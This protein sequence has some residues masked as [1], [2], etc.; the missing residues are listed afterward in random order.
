MVNLN[1]IG[2]IHGS[3][4]YASHT[5]QLVKAL[6]D[7]GVEVYLDSPKYP[8][9]ESQVTDAELKTMKREPFVNSN[10]LA[11]V[12][13]HQLPMILSEAHKNLLVY[14]VWEGSNVPNFWIN[15]FND[16]SIMGILCP[17]KHTENAVKTSLKAFSKEVQ[18]E[19]SSKLILCPHGVDH[20]LFK[21]PKIK[22]ENNKFTFLCNKGWVRGMN[23][24]G[25]LQYALKAFN[26]EFSNNEP[27]QLLVKLNTAYI[28][29][30]WD[31]NNE[32]S[33]LNL[34]P[35]GAVISITGENM[36][37]EKLPDFYNMG[38]VLLA[39]NM[40]ESFGLPLAEAMACG[41][42]CITTNY[43]GQTDFVTK[44]NG[45]LVDYKLKEVTWDVMYEGVSWAEPDLTHFKKCMRE[46]YDN[47]E[48]VKKKGEQAAKD[49]QAYDWKKTAKII[50]EKLV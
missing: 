32:L 4:G 21:T 37:F 31:L 7:L 29:Q 33:K 14:C 22:V 43:G 18:A 5:R 20:N 17:S 9:W 45:W 35:E 6:I 27:V 48:L 13:P 8:G 49:I 39:P 28:E 38:D 41:L 12:L 47:L 10:T 2:H 1:V 30:G 24:R 36:P 3:S 23:D 40:S 50:K 15:Y 16:K 44:E 19:V 11:V 25:G 34:R 26:E 42:P 46:A